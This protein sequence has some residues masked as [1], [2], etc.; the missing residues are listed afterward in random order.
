MLAYPGCL[1]A[2]LFGLADVLAMANTL[3]GVL[4]PGTGAPFRT[5]VV[6][7]REGRVPLAG[8]VTVQ[9]E[10]AGSPPAA[11]QVIVP[12]FECADPAALDGK[13]RALAPEIGFLRGFAG[14]P[15]GVAS[16]CGGAFLL[17]EAGLLD[18]CT[19]TT[20]WLFAPQFG[21]RYPRVDVRATALVVRDGRVMTSAAFSAYIDLA[22]RLV[23]ERAGDQVARAAS[24]VI[25]A[26]QGRTS[27]APFV[28]EQLLPVAHA[29][30]CDD[31]R[32]WLRR[33]MA[34]PYSLGRLASAFNVSTRTMLRR[35][36]AET[37]ES[38]LA[39]LQRTRI[40][41]AQ[42]LLETS[43]L[44]VHTIQRQVGYS[45]AATFRRLFAGHTGITP[46]E[47]RRQFRHQPG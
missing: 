23:R 5:R 44:A 22:L 40:V 19:A 36:A 11:D 38:P 20:S 6:S 45:D 4:L 16:V 7:V 34:E 1:G 8:G 30:F 3:A 32:D 18:G 14:R 31:V 29:R 12:G 46:S 27:Q 39:F 47:Y 17:A 33:R 42:R 41:A 26:A 9:V 24:R 21:R 25:L 28:D 15:S 10:R 37:G 13:L 35:F 43:D 2:V